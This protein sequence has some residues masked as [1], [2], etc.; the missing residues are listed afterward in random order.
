MVAAAKFEMLNMGNKTHPNQPDIGK[1]FLI[2]FLHF[3]LLV[4]NSVFETI[5]LWTKCWR[6]NRFSGGKFHFSFFVEIVL[7][8][9]YDRWSWKTNR[10]GCCF[11]SEKKIIYPDIG[12]HF[13][14]WRKRNSNRL[15]RKLCHVK[16]NWIPSI[17]GTINN[18]HLL[19]RRKW[20]HVFSS[21]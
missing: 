19:L 2:V 13:K 8:N 20:T 11:R 18:I 9:F 16:I 5:F 15:V 12:Y 17:N 10:R 3:Y 1:L 14:Y 21:N 4:L 6:Q 7:L